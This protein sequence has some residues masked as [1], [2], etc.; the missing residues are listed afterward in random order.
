MR[1]LATF[2]HV[3]RDRRIEIAYDVNAVGGTADTPLDDLAEPH[4]QQFCPNF[5]VQTAGG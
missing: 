4:M 1:R 2:T 3:R 5:L